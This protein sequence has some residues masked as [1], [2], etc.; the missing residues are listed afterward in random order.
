M[1]INS[2][3]MKD[4]FK[5]HATSAFWIGLG[6]VVLATLGAGWPI[7][8]LLAS[9]AHQHQDCA[10]PAAVDSWQGLVVSGAPTSLQSSF[11]YG[12]GTQTIE[13]FISVAALKGT[14]L[15]TSINVFASPLISSDGSAVVLPIQSG[16]DP[17][18][19]AAISAVAIQVSSSIY[20]L[21][22]CIRAPNAAPGSYGSQLM[23]PGAS[24]AA[25]SGS[26][27]NATAAVPVTVSFQS[28]AVPYIL[29]MGLVPLALLGM[30]YCTLVLIRRSN[31]D[32]DISGL[33]SS[34]QKQ[35]WSIN[36]IM[37]LILS[38]GAVF[39]AWNLQCYRDA[40][41]GTP[42]PVVLTALV[43]MAGA[44]AGA[45]TIPMGLSKNPSDPS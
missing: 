4:F 18:T 40:T 7:G 9:T 16:E 37:A 35:L 1:L 27:A 19:P 25:G 15:P 21:E 31:K 29:T 14:R 30:L 32:E 23:F 33:P 41:W 2:D 39:A 22:V 38:L 26:S 45:S 12:R 44:A 28:E 36:G 20:R 11:G 6:V 5:E 43:T 13:S 24:S 17:S 10:P 34:L 42:W 8:Q 3:A